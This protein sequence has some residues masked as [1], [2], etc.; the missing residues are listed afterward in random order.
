MRAVRDR[1]SGARPDLLAPRR[2]SG[3]YYG[4]T[5]MTWSQRMRH[6]LPTWMGNWLSGTYTWVRNRSI[7]ARAVSL[8]WERLQ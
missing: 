5:T 4:L 8:R 2:P 6:L 3:L 7:D 1:I